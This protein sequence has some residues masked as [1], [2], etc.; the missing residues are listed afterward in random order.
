MDGYIVAHNGIKFDIPALQKLYPWFTPNPLGVRDTL[1]M[2]R[3]MFPDL[4]FIDEGLVKKGKLPPKLYKRHSLEAWGYRLNDHKQE[5]TGGF[6]QWNPEMEDYCEQDVHAL[7][8]LYAMLAR[9]ECSSQAVH[10]EH[11][12]QWI[13]ARQERYGFLFDQERAGRL[14][15]KLIDHKLKLEGQL[16]VVFRPR[17]LRDGTKEAVP[18]RTVRRKTESEAGLYITEYTEGVPYTKVKLTEFN[19]SSRVHCS[20]WLM[21]DFGWKPTEYTDDGKPK[22]DETTLTGLK[23]PEAKVLADYFMVIKRLGQVV[24]G[25]EAWVR[26]IKADGRIHGQ[27]ITNGAVT[28]RMT[29]SKP[30][31]AQVPASRSPYGHECRELFC[32]PKGK[33]L[34]GADSS[35]LEL[36]CLAGYMEFYDQGAYI[37][38]VVEGKKEDGT[39]IH[40]VNRKALQIESR[41][42]AKTWFYAFIYGAG[43]EKLGITLGAPKGTKAQARGKTSRA[44]FLKNLPALGKLVDVVKKKVATSKAARKL[45]KKPGLFGTLKGLDGRELWCRSEHSALNTL[46]QSAGAIIMKQALVILDENLQ[47]L[48]YLPGINY[49]FVANVHDEWQIECDVGIAEIVGAEAKRSMVL[50]G[51]LLKFACPIDGEFGVGDNWSETH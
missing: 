47:A 2:S 37:K 18:K 27:V 42:D 4:G 28:G 46:L 13:V 3:L 31:M 20:R 7:G 1:V 30:N 39:E 24:E 40:T 33:R 36:R 48:G 5:Y 25:D 44:L 45:A 17:Y 15:A 35:A 32:V 49:E 41:D 9:Q 6:E 38:T 19:P 34:V 16:K 14:H 8:T 26:H 50:A 43:D 51:E 22:V 12:V 21:L 11:Q 10:L 23:W 29:H